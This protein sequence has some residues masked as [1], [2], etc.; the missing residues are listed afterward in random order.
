MTQITL[1]GNPVETIGELPATGTSAKDF[2]LVKNDLSDASLKDYAGKT[3]VLNIFPSIDTPVCANSTRRF[4]KEL[5]SLKNTVVLCV[6]TD[7]PF[8]NRR[9]CG[10]EGLEN[11]ETLSDFRAPDFG[12]DYGVRMTTG[13]MAGL[14][15]RAIV[16][17]DKDGKVSY[18]EQVAE[19]KQDPD[20]EA[21]LKHLS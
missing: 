16:I 14:L 9:F 6:S 8:A 15:S 20:F 3:V 18:T 21:A 4:N 13:P 5:N 10:A 11:V 1:A 12:N 7:L 19:I 2:T 17:I